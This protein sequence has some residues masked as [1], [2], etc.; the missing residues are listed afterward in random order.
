MLFIEYGGHIGLM[1]LT[2]GNLGRHLIYFKMLN[3]ARVASVGFI[4][5]NVCTLRIKK[6]KNIEI[7]FQVIL[8]FYRT[9][10]LDIPFFFRLFKRLQSNKGGKHQESIQSSTTPDPGYHMGK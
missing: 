7:K 5:Y 6:E 1:N 10:S 3:D 4:K 9:I 2:D 8:V